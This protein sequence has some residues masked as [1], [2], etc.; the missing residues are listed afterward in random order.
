MDTTYSYPKL[1]WPLDIQVHSAGDDHALV[2]RCPL[3]ITE[4]PLLLIP[5]VGPILST[6]DGAQSFQQIL[7]RFSPQG[8]DESTL[9]ELVRLLD[10]H[11]FLANAR[12]FA[13]EKEVREGFAASSSRRATLAGLGYPNTAESLRQ[14]VN[15]YLVPYRSPVPGRELVALVS[16]H[17]DYR[18]GGRCYGEIYPRLAE[19]CADLYIVIGTAHQYSRNIFHLCGKD[20][21]SPLGLVSCDVPFVTQLAHRYGIARAFQDEFLHKREHSLELQLPFLKALKPNAAIV[22]I[23]V[24]SFHSMLT[25]NRYPHEWEEYAS[26]AAALAEQ[27]RERTAHGSKVCLIAGVDMAH[28]GRSFGDDGSLSEEKMAEIARRDAEYL[29]AIESRDKKRLFDHIAEDCDARRMCGFP[30]MYTVLDVL[31]QLGWRTA[32]STVK[33]DQAVNY[34]TDCAVTFAGMAM[35]RVAQ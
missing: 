33:Y 4:H 21:E 29:A 31:D 20:F 13:A 34:V 10:E 9:R 35:Y 18:R 24:G 6:F 8:L 17:I 3:G 22:P 15:G 26:F 16:P 28:I 25:R 5:A 32:S 11:R 7:D 30:T 2:V 27:V 19:S 1:R 12:F 14:M 23:L